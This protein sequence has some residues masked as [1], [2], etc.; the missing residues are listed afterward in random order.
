MSSIRRK[1]IVALQMVMFVVALAV[2]GLMVVPRLL[3]WEIVTVLSGSMSP[4]Y[5]VESVLA[6]EAVDPAAVRAGDVIAFRMEDDV[7]PVTHRVLAVDQVNGRRQFVTK[8]DANEDPDPTPVP[9]DAVRGRVVFGVPIL[10]RL[11]RAVRSPAGFALLLVAPAAALT[12]E[13]VRS[14]LSQRRERRAEEQPS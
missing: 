12:V 7:L 14:M 9:A 1:F 4:T 13:E 3:G 11:V 2:A 6:V 10:G 5:P 8:G